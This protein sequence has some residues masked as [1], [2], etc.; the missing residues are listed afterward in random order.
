MSARNKTVIEK[1]NEA[2]AR[3][4]VEVKPSRRLIRK[5]PK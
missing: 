4:D 2:F 3:N 5:S 1:V